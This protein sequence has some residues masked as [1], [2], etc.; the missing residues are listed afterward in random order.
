MGWEKLD[1]YFSATDR[2]PVYLAAVVMNPKLKWRYFEVKWDCDWVRNGKQRLKRY[3]L[4]YVPNQE[5]EN[6]CN[7]LINNRD[8]D[9]TGSNIP[10]QSSQSELTQEEEE[11]RFW[12]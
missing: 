9:P 2:A 11:N 4:Q 6:R 12:A 1:K 3:W 7:A 8:H 10:G 5:E